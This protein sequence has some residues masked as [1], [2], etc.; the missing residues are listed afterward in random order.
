MKRKAQTEY[1]CNMCAIEICIYPNGKM[2]L[3]KFKIYNLEE[4]QTEISSQSAGRSRADS[5][6][7]HP[8]LATG[9]A[10]QHDDDGDGNHGECD[11]DGGVGDDV[12]PFKCNF[13][14]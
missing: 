6:I 12:L 9:D 2:Y 8:K 1:L 3:S 13:M 14:V 11:D 10:K 5:P 4:K 7:Y